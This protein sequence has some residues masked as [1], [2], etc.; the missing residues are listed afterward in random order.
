MELDEEVRAAVTNLIVKVKKDDN[1]VTNLIRF[2][3]KIDDSTFNG[4]SHLNPEYS[5]VLIP[6]ELRKGR[7]TLYDS[8][9]NLVTN[10]VRQGPTTRFSLL[11]NRVKR[12]IEGS[13][14]GI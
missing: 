13:D 8:S 9:E 11:K 12:L 1:R 5:K 2:Y 4:I 6:S 7:F 14:A 10:P 3:E